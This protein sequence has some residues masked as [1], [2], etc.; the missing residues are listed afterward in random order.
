MGGD[1]VQKLRTLHEAWSGLN[2]SQK[3][4][5]RTVSSRVIVPFTT[6][7]VLACMLKRDAPSIPS[8]FSPAKASH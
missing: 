1:A 7:P 5:C 3:Q 8:F 2:E 4:E 6:E